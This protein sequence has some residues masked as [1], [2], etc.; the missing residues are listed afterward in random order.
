MRTDKTLLQP[1]T[2]L[3]LRIISR[4]IHKHP[5]WNVVYVARR[6]STRTIWGNT[7]NPYIFLANLCTHANSVERSSMGRTVWQFICQTPTDAWGT[8]HCCVIKFVSVSDRNRCHFL[9]EYISKDVETGLFSC[10]ACGKNNKDKGNLRKHVEVHFPGHFVYSCSECNKT[11]S[12]KNSL[13]VHQS[14]YH[15]K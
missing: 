15:K 3:S 2:P 1:Q 7:L 4:R 8:S 11:F 13:Y 6:T 9:N 12:G 5:W 10:T 14:T